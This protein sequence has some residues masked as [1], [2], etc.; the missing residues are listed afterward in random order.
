[1]MDE[2]NFDG[3]QK[4]SENDHLPIDGACAGILI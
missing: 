1:M 2:N 4:P 3:V